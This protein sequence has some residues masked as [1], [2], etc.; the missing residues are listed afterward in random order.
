MSWGFPKPT[1]AEIKI[2]K[3]PTGYGSLCARI[4]INLL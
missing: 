4:D 2:Q 1:I 3:D